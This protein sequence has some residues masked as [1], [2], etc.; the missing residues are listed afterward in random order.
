MT[1]HDKVFNDTLHALGRD[2]IELMRLQV[3]RDNAQRV[4]KNMT[5]RRKVAEG[6]ER[7][8]LAEYS[9]ARVAYSTAKGHPLAGKPVRRIVIT[10]RAVI[11]APGQPNRIEHRSAQTGYVTMCGAAGGNH[12]R[13]Y[14]PV[15]GE[16]FVLSRSGITAYKLDGDDWEILNGKI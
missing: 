16:W 1:D 9:A 13:N 10:R 6:L 11:A 5:L 3:A 12:L 4:F 7:Q 15:P 2:D 14:Q 8:A